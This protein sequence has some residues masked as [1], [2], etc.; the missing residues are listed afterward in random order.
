MSTAST[1]TFTLTAAPAGWL[2]DIDRG[3]SGISFLMRFFVFNIAPTLIEIALVIGLLFYN[4]GIEFAA[5]TMA[6]SGAIY[7][8]LS[9]SPPTGAPSSSARPTERTRRQALRSI[10]SLLNYET[11]KYFTNETVRGAAL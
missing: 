4:Y 1:S 3:T 6:L 11:V 10:D 7:P 5:I 2:G 9:W 8:L